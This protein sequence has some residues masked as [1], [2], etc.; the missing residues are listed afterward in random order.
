M[1]KKPLVVVIDP[2]S[3]LLTS[4]YQTLEE[5]G[6]AVATC[7]NGLDGLKYVC[8]NR[9]DGVVCGLDLPDVDALDLLRRVRQVLPE[10]AILALAALRQGYL[11]ADVVRLGNAGMLSRLYAE[12]ELRETVSRMIRRGKSYARV[13]P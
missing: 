13:A 6:Y 10:A 7:P 9:P 3:D 8:R 4:L 12:R 2:D 5:E 11:Y 1:M